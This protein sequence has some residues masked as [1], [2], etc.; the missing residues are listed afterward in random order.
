MLRELP[1]LAPAV[2]ENLV[3]LAKLAK[4]ERNQRN[5]SKI[6]GNS[7][8][9]AKSERNPSEIRAKLAKSERNPS[10]I[11]EIRGFSEK[12]AKLA[13]KLAMAGASHGGSRTL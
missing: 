1:W 6:S 2:A 10:E 3:N 9:R 8:I 12:L 13:E 7:E 5:P 4:S 11:S